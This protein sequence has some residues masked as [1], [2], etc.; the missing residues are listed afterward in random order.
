MK[1]Y[2][3]LMLA[4]CV[5]LSPSC[6]SSYTRVTAPDGTITETSTKGPDANSVAA[7][8]RLG[9]AVGRIY[10]HKILSDK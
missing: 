2:R 9:G 8:S 7:A 4:I 5:L 1:L 6:V 10:L 3:I